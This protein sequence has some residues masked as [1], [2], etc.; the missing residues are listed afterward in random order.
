[1]EIKTKDGRRLWV[2]R[3][4]ETGKVSNQVLCED[5]NGKR[6]FIKFSDIRNTPQC[7]SMP[8]RVE[9]KVKND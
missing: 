4:G 3:I 8:P 5:I 2:V 9:H 1:M 6:V 7:Y